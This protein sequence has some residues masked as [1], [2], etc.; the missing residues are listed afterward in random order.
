MSN[1]N[2]IGQHLGKN[3]ENPFKHATHEQKGDILSE[4]LQTIVECAEDIEVLCGS[5]GVDIE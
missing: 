3:K 2:N 4:Y 1:I 5:V